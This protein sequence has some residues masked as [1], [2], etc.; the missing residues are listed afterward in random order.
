LFSNI[1]RAPLKIPSNLSQEA[2]SLI[3]GVK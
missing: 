3:I 1:E 2:K